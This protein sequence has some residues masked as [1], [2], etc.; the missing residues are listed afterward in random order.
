MVDK[1]KAEIKDIKDV[2]KLAENNMLKFKI[3][4]EDYN[5]ALKNVEFHLFKYHSII[6]LKNYKLELEAIKK[7]HSSKYINQEE[8]YG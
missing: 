3:G 4:T 2:M 5:E 1:F 7:I 8:I 6:A